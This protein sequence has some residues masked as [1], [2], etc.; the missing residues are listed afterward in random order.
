MIFYFILAEVFEIGVVILYG[1]GCW[2][3]DNIIPDK[4]DLIGGSIGLIGVIIIMYA[5]IKDY[6]L[7]KV[8]WYWTIFIWNRYVQGYCYDCR[9]MGWKKSA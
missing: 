7:S 8:P 9:Y 1:Y 3:I 6:C 5:P 2:K 4:F